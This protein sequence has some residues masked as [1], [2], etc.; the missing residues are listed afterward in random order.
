MGLI[1]RR[2]GQGAFIVFVVASLSFGLVHFA[3]GD[4][5]LAAAE[6]SNLSD[7]VR[8]VWKERAGLDKPV[9]EQYVR[10]LANLAR[11]DLGPSFSMHRP[12]ADVLRDAVPNTLLLMG[13]SLVLSFALGIAIGLVQAKRADSRLDHAISTTT[14]VLASLPPFWVG[15]VLMLCFAYWLPVFPVSGMVDAVQHPYMSGGRQLLDRLKHLVLPAATLTLMAAP[16]IARYQRAAL[17]EVLPED[18]IRTARAKGV[19]E[20]SVMSHHA[21]RN[22]FLPTITVFGLSFPT[23]LGGAVFVETVFA[24]PGMGV[25][26]LKALEMR[27][28]PLVIASVIVG[29]TLVVI[30]SLVADLLAAAADPRLRGE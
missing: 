22:A 1:L 29:S 25:A 10:Y 3:P 5:F 9:R 30:G 8:T 21:L 13:T 20:R 12:V 18:F 26:S 6:N 27:D 19:S 11:G 28:Y 16:E 24:W 17:L 23:L 14:T 2:A 15:V 7:S 4:P